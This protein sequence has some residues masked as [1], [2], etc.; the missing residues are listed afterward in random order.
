M[1][2]AYPPLRETLGF[3]EM[4][5]HR[6]LTDAEIDA[7][8]VHAGLRLP[9]DY[10]TFLRSYGLTAGRSLVFPDPDQPDDPDAGGGVGVFYGLQADP[11][12]GYDLKQEWE[13]NRD[14]GELPPG[15]LAV[16]DSPGGLICIAVSGPE[17][18]SVH[19]FAAPDVRTGGDSDFFRISPTFRDFI[20]SLYICDD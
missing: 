18:G 4:T 10:R 11:G 8:E 15:Y 6:E 2:D 16:A 7:F 3:R 14:L 13:W 20:L 17:V 9:Q 19:W 5:G 12:D 1:T